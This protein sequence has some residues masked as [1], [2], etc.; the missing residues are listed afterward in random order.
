LAKKYEKY[1]WSYFVL[2]SEVQLTALR[3]MLAQQMCGKIPC[4]EFCENLSDALISDTR[5]L[6]DM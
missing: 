5:S 4:T 6:T 2:L 1:M 3:N